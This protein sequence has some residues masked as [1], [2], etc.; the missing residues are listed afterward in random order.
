VN[1]HSGGS[2]NS[3][4]ERN[5]AMTHQ[6]HMLQEH[7]L[8]EWERILHWNASMHGWI[9]KTNDFSI[10]IPEKVYERSMRAYLTSHSI[11]WKTYLEIMRPAEEAWKRRCDL[12]H[13]FRANLEQWLS[14]SEPG[15]QIMPR[16]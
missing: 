15:I 14:S 10:F 1:Y 9:G 8:C 12:E 5:D 16:K 11:E 7:A 6:D 13:A 4:G 3:E 2:I